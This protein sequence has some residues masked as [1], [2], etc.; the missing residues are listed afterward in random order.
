[1]ANI[2]QLLIFYTFLHSVSFH[3]RQVMR[4]VRCICV[5]FASYGRKKH[6]LLQHIHTH[7]HQAEKQ[8]RNKKKIEKRKQNVVRNKKKSI[9]KEEKIRIIIYLCDS[10]RAHTSEWR[11]LKD[12]INFQKSNHLHTIRM[13]NEAKFARI[14]FIRKLDDYK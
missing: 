2:I 10:A 7:T 14:E 8:E 3:G 11:R 4:Y 13:F 1:M 9:C 5:C 6:T 12:A